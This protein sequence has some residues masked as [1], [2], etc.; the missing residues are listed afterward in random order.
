[1][2]GASR[3]E[4]QGGWVKSARE[5]EGASTLDWV[6]PEKKTFQEKI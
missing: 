2:L 6:V 1:M 5:K 4:K 3:K